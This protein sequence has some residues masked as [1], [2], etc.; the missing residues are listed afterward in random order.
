MSMGAGGED[1][2]GR[3]D[4]LGFGVGGCAGSFDGVDAARRGCGGR[5]G[6]RGFVDASI[7]W[8]LRMRRSLIRR[9]PW[10]G[11]GEAGADREAVGDLLED[12]G[13]G[14]VGDFAGYLQTTNHGAGMKDERE[15]A[16]GGEAGGV[17]LVAVHILV[18]VE[19]KAGEAFAL[20]A[21]IAT[22]WERSE[23]VVE[24][25]GDFRFLLLSQGR[26]RAGEVRDH[27]G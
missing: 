23:G 12:G 18:E 7:A 10:H 22:T 2:V 5:S 24:V 19:F 3:V 13:V 21:N 26:L 4:G 1:E 15:G 11:R 17:E 6:D 25:T 9:P 16:V 20:D 14:A 8:A 27:R